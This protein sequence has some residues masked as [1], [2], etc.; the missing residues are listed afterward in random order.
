M[1]LV[2]SPLA[3]CFI[4]EP[5][6]FEDE[7]G[8]FYEKYNQAQFEQS[9]GMNGHFV[10]DN[11]SKSSFGVIRGIHWQK[12]EHAQAK[13]VSCLEGVVWDVAV[14]LRKNSP[15]FGKW[16]GVELSEKNKLQFY[17]PRGFGHGF[18]VLSDTAVFAYK[19]DNYYKKE[20]EG[21]LIWND[22]TLKIDWKLPLEKVIISQKDQEL[23]SFSTSDF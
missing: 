1:K 4:I 20:S 19:C 17:I 10:Q 11:L 6:L 14:D 23:P 18:S 22:S 15:T 21:G 13:L 5:T 2:K 12:G 8:Y 9:T 7:R 3:D 16:Y